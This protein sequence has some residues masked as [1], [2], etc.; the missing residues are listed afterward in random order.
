MRHYMRPA[1]LAA[2]PSL[3]AAP[4][5]KQSVCAPDVLMGGSFNVKLYK[6]IYNCQQ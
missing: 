5:N 3:G 2:G 1:S 6:H 4:F